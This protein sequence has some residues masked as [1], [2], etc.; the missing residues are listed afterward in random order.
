MKADIKTR[1]E[2]IGKW[3]ACLVFVCVFANLAYDLVIN[4]PKA[5]ATLAQL[6]TEFQAIE[7]GAGATGWPSYTTSHKPSQG[8]VSG[9]FV[10]HMPAAEGQAYYDKILVKNGWKFHKTK[11]I[12]DYGRDLGE[13]VAYYCKGEY[14]AALHYVKSAES[15]DMMYS[16]NLSWGLGGSDS[17]Q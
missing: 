9:R 8:L 1:F 13:K 15:N 3:I 4:E 2:K 17:C 12:K 10:R 7:P 14:Q 6:E 16:L 11:I 5:K